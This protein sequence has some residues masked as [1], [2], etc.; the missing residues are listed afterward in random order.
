M[1]AAIFFGCALATT[2]VISGCDEPVFES[3]HL[4]CGANDE[5][6]AGF[7]CAD[8][9]RCW[10]DGQVPDLQA[11][12]LDLSGIFAGDLANP[13]DLEHIDLATIDGCE[14]PPPCNCG[15]LTLACGESISCGGDCLDEMQLCGGAG[16]PNMCGCPPSGRTGVYR[17]I[18][19]DGYQ[20][21]LAIST[22]ECP[23]FLVEGSMP[24]FYVYGGDPPPG[25]IPLLRCLENG[26]YVL[27]EDSNCGGFGASAIDG[28]VGYVGPADV[29]GTVPLHRYN[30]GGLA[31]WFYTTDVNEAP[32]AIAETLPPYW[33]WSTP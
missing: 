32:P 6:P 21:C 17:K 30:V 22:D 12:L 2:F 28:T 3:G 15:V 19:S 20:H 26:Q 23:N 27:E 5:C 31:G 14:V 11:P 1:R 16:F 13:P 7:Y 25:T 29:C 33:V 8:D 10:L 9:H 4:Q 18:S 24:R